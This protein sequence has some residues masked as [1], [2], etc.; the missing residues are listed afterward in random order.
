MYQ[1]GGNCRFL[2]ETYEPELYTGE[3]C[4]HCLFKTETRVSQY[5]AD[6]FGRDNSI[7]L[8]WEP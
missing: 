8:E 5:I 4:P 2:C 7:Y 3:G 6:K 1:H